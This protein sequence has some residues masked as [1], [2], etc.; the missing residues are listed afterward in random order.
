MQLNWQTHPIN[1]HFIYELYRKDYKESK[2]VAIKPAKQPQRKEEIHSLSK[3]L[4]LVRCGDWIDWKKFE[5]QYVLR[6]F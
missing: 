3:Y 5:K 2:P 4:S 1:G 6:T